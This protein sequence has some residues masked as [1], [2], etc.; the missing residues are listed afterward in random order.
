MPTVVNDPQANA[1]LVQ[2]ITNGLLQIEQAAESVKLLKEAKE[3]YDDV[4]SA[5]QTI[6][7]VTDLANISEKIL[8]ESGKDLREIQKSNVF[9]RKEMNVISG[10]YQ[11]LINK[12]NT[13][14]KVANDLLSN[15]IFKMNDA[16]R[17]TLLKSQKRELQEILMDTRIG[18]DN[19][20]RIAKGRAM[21]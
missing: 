1:S 12:G 20:M 8:E 4:N 19:Y 14:F 9:S 5:L 16:E 3:L 2:T 17:L 10:N 7:Y 13:I 6:D 18:R 15:G 11:K 21:R